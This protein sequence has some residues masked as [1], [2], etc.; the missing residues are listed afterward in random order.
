MGG[1]RGDRDKGDVGGVT[2]KRAE[3]RGW[4]K[5][6]RAGGGAGG[7]GGN[8]V[9]GGGQSGEGG[10]GFRS[11]SVLIVSSVFCFAFF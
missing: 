8:G 9:E 11:Y 1:G 4:D 2:G 10:G 7:G 5:G 3:D 6:R